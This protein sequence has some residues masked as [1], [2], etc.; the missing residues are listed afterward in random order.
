MDNPV[1]EAKTILFPTP[2]P[3]G[4]LSMP[5]QVKLFNNLF[6]LLLYT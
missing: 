5:P 6:V 4:D 2:E 1:L 3:P